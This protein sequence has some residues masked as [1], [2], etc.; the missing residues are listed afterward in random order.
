[1]LVAEVHLPFHVRITFRRCCGTPFAVGSLV[2]WTVHPVTIR[3]GLTVR[4]DADTA[5]SIDAQEERHG[6]PDDP[7]DDADMWVVTGIVMS[8]WASYCRFALVSEWGSEHAPVADTGHHVPLPDTYG[9][10]P[11]VD[12]LGFNGYIVDLNVW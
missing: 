3:A 7:D 5:N 2:E 4:T 12:G 1:M 10:E 6:G 8:I 9:A 11:D